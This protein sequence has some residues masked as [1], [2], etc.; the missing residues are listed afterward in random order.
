MITVVI[1]VVGGLLWVVT[2]LG[3]STA[4]AVSE[5]QIAGSPRN[6]EGAELIRIGD[7]HEIQNHLQEALPYYER[8]VSVYRRQRNRSGEAIALARLGRVL[9]RQERYEDALKILQSADGLWGP[10]QRIERARTLLDLGEVSEK[11][12]RLDDAGR[13]YAESRILFSQAKLSEGALS[14]MVRLGSLLAAQ[15]KTVE[16]ATLLEQAVGEAQARHDSPLHLSALLALGDAKAKEDLGVAVM[17]YEEALQLAVAQ[18]D[19]E[20]EAAVRS[21]LAYALESTARHDAAL[22]MASKALALYQSLRDRSHEAEMLLLLGTLS[23]SSRQLT[24]AIEYH[25]RALGL[26]RALRDRRR[27]AATL[28]ILSAMYGEQGAADT[29]QETQEKAILLLSPSP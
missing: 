17:I 10:P 25:E 29:A 20:H 8:A 9:K 1:T 23:R 7:L 21:R 4:S 13:A 12:G 27:E 11:L 24:A 3:I 19:R 2:G 6:L 18:H 26:Y 16:A 22:D 5:V 14:S 28:L 15:G